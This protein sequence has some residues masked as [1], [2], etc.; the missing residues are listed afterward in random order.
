MNLK[1]VIVWAAVIV[2]AIFAW[3]ALRGQSVSAGQ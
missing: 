2:L 3:K 1:A